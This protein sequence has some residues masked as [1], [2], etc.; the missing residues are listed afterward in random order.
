M[1][2]FTPP[3]V[4]IFSE[5]PLEMGQIVIPTKHDYLHLSSSS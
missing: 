1:R 2:V 3:V 4:D 5:Y